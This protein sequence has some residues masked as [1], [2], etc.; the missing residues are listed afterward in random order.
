MDAKK[1]LAKMAAAMRE[2]ARFL[3]ASAEAIETLLP[4]MTDAEAERL[5]KIKLTEVDV[6]GGWACVPPPP[7]S[8]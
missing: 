1:E 6:D 4:T 3:N 5:A 7:F 2:E 8:N